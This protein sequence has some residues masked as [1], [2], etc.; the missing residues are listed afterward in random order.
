[1][2]LDSEFRRFDGGLGLG[3]I[4]PAAYSVYC[5]SQHGCSQHG[6]GAD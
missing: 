2:S 6:F 1:M 4:T 3:L 5:G